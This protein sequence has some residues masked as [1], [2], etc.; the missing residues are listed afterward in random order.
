[1]YQRNEWLA[2]I[3][4]GEKYTEMYVQMGCENVNGG[5]SEEVTA[6]NAE[7]AW[8]EQTRT[9]TFAARVTGRIRV[10]L[11]RARALR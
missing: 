10:F 9:L 2:S 5:G 6:S 8:I 3:L 7:P 11:R 1:M 4:R